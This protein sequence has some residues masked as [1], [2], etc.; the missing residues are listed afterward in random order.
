M[1]GS[2]GLPTDYSVTGW[3]GQVD[4]RL[5]IHSV[6]EWVRWITNR[7]FSDWMEGSGGL[8]TRYSFGV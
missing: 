1:E 4:Y 5:D 2:G 8:L 6:Y 3:R 7:I